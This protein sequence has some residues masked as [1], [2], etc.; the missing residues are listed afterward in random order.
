MI[1]DYFHI[2]SLSGS[3]SEAYSPLIVNANTVLAFALSR[4]LFQTVSGRCSEI[5]NQISTLYQIQLAL[6]YLL[7]RQRKSRDSLPFEYPLGIP[8]SKGFDHE[9]N[10]NVSRY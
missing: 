10:D 5:F 6:R 9:T 4:E 7:N 8:V 3:P 1:V 2:S